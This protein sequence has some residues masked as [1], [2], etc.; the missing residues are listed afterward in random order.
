MKNKAIFF[1]VPLLVILLVVSSCGNNSNGYKDEWH[2]SNGSKIVCR[3]FGCEN[4]PAYSNWDDRFC[5]EHLNKSANH[6]NEYDSSKAKKKINTQKALTKEEADALRG[7][8]YHGT[9]P[10]SSAEETELSAAMVT[11]KNCGMHSDNGLNSLCDECQYNQEYGF[12]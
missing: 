5:S 1:I 10:N 6:S 9:R 7:T 2:N 4:T 11:C 3:V 8:G 12:N